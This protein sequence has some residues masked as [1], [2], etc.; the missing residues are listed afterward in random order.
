[1]L[2]TLQLFFGTDAFDFSVQSTVG[3]LM[4][5][6]RPYH[7]FSDAMQDIVYVRIYQGIHFRSADEEGRR[8]GARVAHWVFSKFL[9]PVAGS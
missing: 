3:G 2:T 9:R 1:M 4:L 6:P 8:Q 7:R 5:N